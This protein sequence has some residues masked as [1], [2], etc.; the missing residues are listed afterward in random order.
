[1]STKSSNQKQT[2]KKP[3]VADSN[4]EKQPTENTENTKNVEKSKKSK[5]STEDIVAPIITPISNPIVKSSKKLTKSKNEVIAPVD[6]LKKSS[7]LDSKLASKSKS[8]SIKTDNK[9]SSPDVS[10]SVKKS[11]KIEIKN[12]EHV[13]GVEGVEGVEGAEDE[14]I[15]GPNGLRYFKLDYEGNI[16]GRYSGK[17][18]KQAA[19]KAYSSVVKKEGLQKGG[20]KIQ[21]SIK[22]CTR[23]SKQK[24]Y[25]YDAERVELDI[26]VEVTIKGTNGEEKLIKYSFN[27]KLSKA[28]DLV[29]LD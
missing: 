16:S 8:S 29:V 24:K 14:D 11:K 1:M 28:K 2:E 19:N 26:P 17:K 22:E 25:T 27:N 21:F 20:A 13:K 4:R 3:K 6:E 9:A 10:K 12:D 7:K 15:K 23:G 5:S 18:P